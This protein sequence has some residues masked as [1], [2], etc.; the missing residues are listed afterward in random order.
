[1]MTCNLSKRCGEASN[2]SQR[3]P[4]LQVPLNID[5]EQDDFY[6]VQARR[7]AG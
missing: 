6:E 2:T 4:P 3:A 7:V 5:L 1:M